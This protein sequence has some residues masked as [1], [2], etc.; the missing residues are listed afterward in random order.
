MSTNND[1]NNDDD[2]ESFAVQSSKLSLHDTGG[3][4]S[5]HTD[6]HTH[7]DSKRGD[8]GARSQRAALCMRTRRTERERAGE[9]E[10]GG[11]ALNVLGGVP[12]R[13]LIT[14]TCSDVVLPLLLLFFALCLPR[15]SQRRRATAATTTTTWTRVARMVLVRARIPRIEAWEDKKKTEKNRKSY[16][17]DE[18]KEADHGKLNVRRRCACVFVCVCVCVGALMPW[19]SRLCMD[20]CV[21]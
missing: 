20:T 7:T 13:Q 19:T 3:S 6:I 9:S 15:C 4:R 21:P 18:E 1:D 11:I 16:S 10:R 12:S 8:N 14:W 2:L 17:R 5:A